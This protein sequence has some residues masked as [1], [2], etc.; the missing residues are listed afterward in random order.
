MKGSLSASKS[1]YLNG[2]SIFLSVIARNS[3]LGPHIIEEKIE[4][5]GDEEYVSS[6][7]MALKE[8]DTGNWKWTHQIAF[9][10]ELALVEAMD[11]S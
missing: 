8:E 7:G 3:L 2:L 6:Y 10:A 11:L 5:E 9:F 4:G 1:T